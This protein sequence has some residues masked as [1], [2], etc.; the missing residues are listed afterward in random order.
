[1]A[2]TTSQK[3]RTYADTGHKI[4]AT[5]RRGVLRE[6]AFRPEYDTD[7]KPWV[8]AYGERFD[9]TECAPLPCHNPDCTASICQERW[10]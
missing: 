3:L 4:Y 6:V 10:I 8:S 2:K 7:R 5:T 1:M 9:G